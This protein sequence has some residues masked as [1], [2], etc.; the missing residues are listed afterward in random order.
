MSVQIARRHFNVSEFYR[1]AEAGIFLEDDRVELVRGEIVEMSPI[2][3]RH[4]ACVGRL[5]ELFS[6]QSRQKF[7]VWVQNPIRLDESSEPE[8]DVVLL[9][10][11]SDFYAGGH[12][13]PEDVLLVVEVAD[14]S[15][16]YDRTVKTPL[17]AQAGIPE[18]WLVDL[19]EDAVEVYAEP[20]NGAYQA[21]R[22]A[23][24]GDSLTAQSVSGLTLRMD[25]ILG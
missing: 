12:P 20:V 24:R 10:R 13:A 2:G 11:R 25:A 4:A 22:Q 23:K 21:F 7:I 17:Y 8:P 16:E 15:A 3:S 1:M 5:T 19:T 9:N 6:R 14:T 18:V